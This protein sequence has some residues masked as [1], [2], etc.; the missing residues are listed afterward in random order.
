M[1]KKDLVRDIYL[2][3]LSAFDMRK[4]VLNDRQ[5]EAIC[6]AVLQNAKIAADVFLKETK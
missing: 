1:G 3:M 4:E 6:K 2:A 5:I